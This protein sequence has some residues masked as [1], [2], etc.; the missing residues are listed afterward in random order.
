MFE[1]FLKRV[2]PKSDGMAATGGGYSQRQNSGSLANL[3]DS[4]TGS[5]LGRKRSK[6]RVSAIERMLRL[7]FEQKC[8]IAQ[9]ELE[10]YADKVR[11]DHE[12]S[13]KEIDGLKVMPPCCN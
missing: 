7:N 5:R 3:S 6:S 8:E 11:L 1:K 4:G 10:D 9:R 2:E 13:E 12:E